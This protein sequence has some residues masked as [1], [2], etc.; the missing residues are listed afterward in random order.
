MKVVKRDLEKWNDL[1]T[2]NFELAKQFRE[3]LATLRK[4][5]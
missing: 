3:F 2:G 5:P 1:T 4:I